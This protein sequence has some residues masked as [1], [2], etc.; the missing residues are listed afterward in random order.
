MISQRVAAADAVA[1]GEE[2]ALLDAALGPAQLEGGGDRDAEV[3]VQDL[4]E[5][6]GEGAGVLW[7]GGGLF[8][9]GA[10]EA[11]D[12]GGGQ[13]FAAGAGR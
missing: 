11:V 7:A 5:D 10:H 8:V 9:E 6:V 13:V 4:A 1:A 2:Q 3:A 12:E